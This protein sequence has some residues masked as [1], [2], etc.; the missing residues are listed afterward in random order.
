M[1]HTDHGP[2]PSA[3]GSPGALSDLSGRLADAR[4]E[5]ST[6]AVRARAGVR[7]LRRYASRIDDIL[8]DI[9]GAARE[10]TDKPTVLIPLGG[11]GRRHLCQ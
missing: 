10:I 7:T 4:E 8:K 5:L 6:E 1:P 9:Y 2:S 11:Y 3:V